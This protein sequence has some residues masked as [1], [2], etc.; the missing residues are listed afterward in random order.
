MRILLL[1]HAF[2]SLTQRLGAEL[3]KRGHEI[4]IEFDIADSVAEEAVALFKPD[5]IVAPY[6]RR[7]IP[8]AIWRQHVCLIVH[9]GV[10]GD[11][12]PSALD[13]AIQGGE[14]EWGVAVLQAEAEMDAGPIW[15]SAR[16]PMRGAKKSSLYRNEVTQAATTAVLEAVARFAAGDFRPTPLAECCDARGSLRP[17]MKQTDRT[18]DWQRDDTATVLRKINAADGFP[19]VADALF[20]VACHIFDAWP[21]ARLHGAP[22]AQPG[23]LLARRETA[24][25][26]KTV[27]GAL[28]I[29]HVKRAGDFKLPTTL[30]F[31]AESAALPEAPLEDW[32]RV[33][34][35]T[36]QDIAYEETGS[37]ENAVG[38]LHFEFYNGAMSTAQCQRLR[39]ALAWA[40]QRPVKVLVLMGGA[41]FWSNGIH[42]NVIEAASLGDG[43]AADESWHN[44]NAMNDLARELIEAGDQITVAALAG[45]AGA[46]GCFL[47]RAA[48]VVWAREGV[49]LNPHYKNMGNLYGSEY[50]TY[51]LPKRVGPEAAQAIM[52]NR[53][54]LT[55]RRAVQT[56]F[57][58]ACLAGDTQAFRIDVA[59]RAAE[60]AAAPDLAARLQAKRQRRAA[61]EAEKPLAA[62]REE[63]LA[64][65][66]R[67]FYGFDPSYHVARHHFV[68]KS[69]A[70][71]TPRHLARHRDLGWKG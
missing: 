65:M 9:P 2:N 32:W 17:L 34:H 41:D 10:I 46:G 64:H 54:P 49:I 69:L 59:R 66:R 51:L 8:E 37:D 15:A 27:D 18:I 36:W 39:A 45:N 57:I 53:Q 61:D 62:Y 21:E 58:D 35:E 1:T 60:I 50:W 26:R 25:L 38:F 11:R 52:R 55:A 71:W 31:V 20:G 47:A 30:A 28:W 4:S 24:V 43:S 68:R 19:G 7:A 40:K 67:N 44:I 6:L 5:L 56:E 12:G 13:W 29:G 22:E 70:S 48:D 14:A 33:D 42:L 16:F 3:E 23:E 63:E